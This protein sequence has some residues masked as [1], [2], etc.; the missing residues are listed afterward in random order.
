MDYKCR[1]VSSEN[2]K[3]IFLHYIPI[4]IENQK[5]MRF[6]EIFRRYRNVTPERN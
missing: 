2:L 6:P 5:N 1:L 3:T 4:P